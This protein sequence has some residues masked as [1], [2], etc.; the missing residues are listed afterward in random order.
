MKITNKMR[1]K[2]MLDI[3]AIGGEWYDP[4]EQDTWPNAWDSSVVRIVVDHAIRAN[5]KRKKS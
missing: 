5:M 2:Y 3:K 4:E 1:I